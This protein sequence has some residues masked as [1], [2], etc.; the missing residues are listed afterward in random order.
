MLFQIKNRYNDSVLFEIEADS[1][2]KAVERAVREKADLIG[3]NLSGAD[4]IG[5]N[6]SG[7]DL[8][9]ANLR[10]ANLIGAN[11]RD[12]NL[13][14][15]DLIGANL[16]DA[17]LRDLLKAA[18]VSSLLQAIPWGNIT[19]ELTLEMMAHDAESCG[20]KKMDEWAKGGKCPFSD[21]VRD[22]YF[23]ESRGVWREAKAENKKPKYRGLILLIKLCDAYGIKTEGVTV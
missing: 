20:I 3:A 12:A 19:S 10:Y 18:S 15:A 4:L 21:G 9:G 22:Y 5:A 2:V 23:Q 13:R 11:L 17:N 6:L 7:A 14:Y 8:S 16:R 1:F